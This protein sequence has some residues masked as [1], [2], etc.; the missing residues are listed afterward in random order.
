M[1]TE[2]PCKE[3]E[4]IFNEKKE[5]NKHMKV[6]H[7][8]SVQKCRDYEIGSCKR[9]NENCWFIH[10]E[11][12]KQVEEASSEDVNEE[13]VFPKVQENLPPDQSKQIMEML[14]KLSI[15]VKNLENLTLIEK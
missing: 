3:C 1:S 12:T 5:L 11:L 9:S 14:T 7:A 6:K 8:R 15:K 13:Q 4:Q 10:E 2:F